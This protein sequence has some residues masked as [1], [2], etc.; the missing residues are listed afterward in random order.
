MSIETV[1]PISGHTAKDGFCDAS[2]IVN[3]G[4][5]RSDWTVS[6]AEAPTGRTLM[7]TRVVYASA[8]DLQKSIDMGLEGG[9][10]SNMERLD[11]LLPTLLA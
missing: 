1:T 3:P 4:M 2:G 10:A 7:T 8:D 6:F 9:M 5:P 11:E